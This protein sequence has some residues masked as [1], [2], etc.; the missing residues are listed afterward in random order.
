MIDKRN[1]YSDAILIFCIERST[2]NIKNIGQIISENTFMM[3]PT[4]LFVIFSNQEFT[5]LT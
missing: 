1:I 2:L 3:C 5:K 4:F